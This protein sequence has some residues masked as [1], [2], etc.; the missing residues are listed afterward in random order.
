VKVGGIGTRARRTVR[1]IEAAVVAAILAAAIYVLTAGLAPSGLPR[2]TSLQ[3]F[4]RRI[5]A[6]I[7]APNS[8]GG[9]GVSGVESVSCSMPSSWSTGKTF[10]CLAFRADEIEAG[11]LSGV[12]RSYRRD[13]QW[14][15]ALEWNGG[16]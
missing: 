8:R 12:V 11:S 7:V 5:E 1:V 15:A 4:E 16:A 3:A 2:G 6:E 9:F 13:G 10:T 14:D